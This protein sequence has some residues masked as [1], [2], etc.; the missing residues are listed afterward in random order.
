MTE[1]QVFNLLKNNAT[2]NT[3][4]NGRIFPLVAPQNVVKP[5]MT[6]RVI[7]GLRL[8]CM[9]GAIYQG[10]FRFQIDVWGLT[11]SNVKAISEAVKN[12]LVGFMDSNNINI[13]DDY[14]NETQL[15]RQIIDFKI[16]GQ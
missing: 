8:Q 3:L 16:K 2:L 7:S 14:E 11:Y 4:I 10:N 5:Y 12:C 15:F 9:S 6:Y 13:M 1:I